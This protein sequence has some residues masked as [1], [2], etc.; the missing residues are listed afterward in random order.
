ML[1]KQ[2][3]RSSGL[4]RI[5]PVSVAAIATAYPAAVFGIRE[6][7]RR[8]VSADAV[9]ECPAPAPLPPIDP[10]Y[11]SSAARRRL[12]NLQPDAAAVAAE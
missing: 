5:G 10:K 9:R 3:N 4:P 11:L 7:E 1:G 2:T 6:R 8:I 12:K